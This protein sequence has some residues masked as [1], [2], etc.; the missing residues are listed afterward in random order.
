MSDR[1][2]IRAHGGAHAGAGHFMRCLALAEAWLD[3]GGAVTFA[4]GPGLGSL[5]S[6]LSGGGMDVVLLDS[7]PGSAEDA[8]ATRRVAADSGAAAVVLDGYVFDEEYVG[9]LE[10]IVPTMIVDDD[11]RW[12]RYPVQWVLNQNLHATPSMYEGKAGAARLLLG[13]A[14]ALIREE[15]RRARPPARPRR[16]DGPTRILVTLGGADPDN[17][18]RTAVEALSGLTGLDA[19]VRVV[20]GPLYRGVEDLRSRIEGMGSGVA[21]SVAPSDFPALMAWADL[22]ISAAGSTTWELLHFGVPL[23]L[24][25]LADN[26]RGI[27]AS[28]ARSGAAVHLGWHASLTAE[29]IR[30]AVAS[31]AADRA[32]LAAM[33]AQGRLLIDGLGATRVAH[34]LRAGVTTAGAAT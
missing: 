4:T 13:P 20:V 10:E 2:L 14:Y 1:L 8:A 33:A 24:I 23:L 29:S 7:D 34:E 6:R 30:D 27:A 5:Q 12:S 25:T 17:V 21:L 11:G 19:E 9:A 28:A 18:T 32:R 26:Q 3:Q 31:L 15:L 16:G 22:A